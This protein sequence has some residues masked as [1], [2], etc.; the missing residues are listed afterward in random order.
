MAR[1]KARRM[2]KKD[3]DWMQT[4]V[5]LK[6]DEAGNSN[7]PYSD[8]VYIDTARIASLLNRKLV[9]QGQLFRIRNLRA[10]TNDTSPNATLKVGVI[11]TTWVTRNAWVKA[12]AL[13]DK[14][15]A[16]AAEDVSGTAIYPKYHDF[17]V[18][19]EYN[20][21]S[22]NTGSA[23]EDLVPRDFFDNEINSGEWKYSLFADSGSTSDEYQIHMM[24]D[25]QG[26]S[27]AWTS[28]GLIQAYAESRT[29]P[30]TNVTTHDQ[31]MIDAIELSP[32]ARLFGDDDQTTEV[33]QNLQDLNDSPP[34]DPDTYIG[35]TTFPQPS[36][37]GFG[38][39]QTLNNTNGTSVSSL[40]PTFIAPCGLIRIEIDGETSTADMQGVHI[41]FDFDILGPMDM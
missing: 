10:Y 34:Y 26:S 33:I 16:M 40:C 24:G 12:K 18:H 31:D 32:W 25:H 38:R 20:H 35:G 2:K 29:Y 28:V 9:R 5:H 17:K 14:M 39:I 27:G 23:D 8:S 37:V 13:W 30:K 21:Y 11:P 22:E 1:S 41:S 19:M 6:W 15:N 36:V 4:H 3:Y 7:T